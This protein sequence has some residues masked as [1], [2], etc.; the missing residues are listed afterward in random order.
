M[1]PPEQREL[2]RFSLPD[3]PGPLLQT[4][5]DS[6]VLDDGA[7]V[8]A[9]MKH[10]LP[11]I[12]QAIADREEIRVLEECTLDRLHAHRSDWWRAEETDWL[13]RFA[14][15]CAEDV[16]RRPDY[17]GQYLQTLAMFAQSGLD[18]GFLLADW[19]RHA[20]N[21]HAL[22]AFVDI[23]LSIPY[24]SDTPQPDLEDAAADEALREWF[25]QT[26]TR[27]RFHAALEQALLAGREEP[28]ETLLWEQCYDWLGARL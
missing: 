5:L 9:E 11:R 21:L 12:A 28:H 23:W 20:H 1:S 3:I 6:V 17:E 7:A 19:T 16:M 27:A 14:A 10:F 26:A 24:G 15:A 22:R 25:A 4:Y 8:V 13:Q 2:L 18:I